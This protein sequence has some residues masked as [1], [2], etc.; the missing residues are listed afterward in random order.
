M[1]VIEIEI[2]YEEKRCKV[3]SAILEKTN[4]KGYNST[5]VLKY[6]L[7]RGPDELRMEKTITPFEFLELQDKKVG[8]PVR[9]ER[10]YCFYEN[11]YLIFDY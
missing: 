11:N 6:T 9:T 3:K 7:I 1:E 2:K 5:Y 4:I 8:E 10:I